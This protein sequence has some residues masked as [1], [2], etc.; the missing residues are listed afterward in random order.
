MINWGI[1]GFGNM[2][3]QYENCFRKE[4]S[5]FNL[6]G[7]ASK[8][9]KKIKNIT[10]E[11]KFFDTYEDLIKS[12]L[13]D[14]IYVSTLNNSHK[15]L[16][17]LANLHDKKILCEKP[18]GMNLSE[19][20]ELFNLLKNKKDN[21]IEAIA[22]RSHPQTEALLQLLGDKEI[23]EIKKIE[24][25]FGFKVKKIR[26]NS[27]LFNKKLGGGAILDLG[28]Y[29]LSFFN[30]LKG[31]KKMEIVKSNFNLCETN[32]DIDGEIILDIDN[33][34]EAVG[35]VSLRENLDNI[36]KIYCDNVQIT[37]REPWLPTNK[38]FIEVETKSRYYKK[39]ISS[40]KSVYENQLEA[41]SIFFSKN[42]KR[43][44]LLV[45]IDESLELSK[46]IEIWKNGNN[47]N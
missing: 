16:V 35:K 27:R 25:S 4:S 30:L 5:I 40:N 6:V 12:N 34:I 44:N 7:I 33:N 11:V 3:R 13:I 19:V 41:S 18:L 15:K 47:K 14:A 21:F 17:Y 46:M 2:G 42:D 31:N 1:I 10:R 36:C 29:P 8:S 24:S 38:S 26:K 28:C 22:Y 32:V 9:K 39:I 43:S 23:G 20:E 45:N 37:L